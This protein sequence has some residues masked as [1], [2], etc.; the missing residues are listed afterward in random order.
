MRKPLC[1]TLSIL[2]IHLWST[3]SLAAPQACKYVSEGAVQQAWKKIRI[4]RVGES[5]RETALAGANT[6]S[7][8]VVLAQGLITQQICTPQLQ[9]CRMASEGIVAGV[10]MK[11]RIQM[12]QEMVFGAD[13]M[14]T[15]LKQLSE[16]RRQGFCE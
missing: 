12:D 4:Q 6:F 7:E 10:W 5:S 3:L 8:A 1:I 9:D 14:A 16:L 2:S 11:H 15:A 13:D